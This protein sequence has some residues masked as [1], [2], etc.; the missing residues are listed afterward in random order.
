MGKTFVFFKCLQTLPKGT[1]VLF[2]AE[3]KVRKNTVIDDAKFFK[4]VY[5]VDPFVGYNIKFALYI[6]PFLLKTSSRFLFIFLEKIE[7]LILT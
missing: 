5:S 1:N 3:T 4:Q 6:N 2:L 7:Y